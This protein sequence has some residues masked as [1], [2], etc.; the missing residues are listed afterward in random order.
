M[1]IDTVCWFND[2]GRELCKNY[3]ISWV[4]LKKEIS[5]LLKENEILLDEMIF[6][7]SRPNTAI[8]Q[9]LAGSIKVHG[10]GSASTDYRTIELFNTSNIKR[11]FISIDR[12]T[13]GVLY[14]HSS[15][16]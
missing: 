7:P 3:N 1:S 5:N 2:A 6:E 4:D 14:P 16:R 12:V 10:D 11:T 8:I 13:V 9:P 15:I